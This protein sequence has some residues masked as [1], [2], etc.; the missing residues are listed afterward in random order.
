[1]VYVN[2][3]GCRSLHT[4][5]RLQK[6]LWSGQP[7]GSKVRF[8]IRPREVSHAELSDWE[9]PML[10]LK[11]SRRGNGSLAEP[12]SLDVGPP[13][14]AKASFGL[15]K[16]CSSS[17]DFPLHFAPAGW[18]PPVS[19]LQWICESQSKH[20]HD[21]SVVGTTVTPGGYDFLN[22]YF[23]NASEVLT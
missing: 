22:R 14:G 5:S 3:E 12:R 23:S 19:G 9:L 11:G 20:G 8:E 15:R 4:F 17:F 13:R 1:M 10:T 2:L 6:K 18:S 16:Y 21:I 7:G